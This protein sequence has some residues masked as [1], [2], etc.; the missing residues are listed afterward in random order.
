MKQFAYIV[1]FLVSVTSI[2]AGDKTVYNPHTGNLDI[3]RSSESLKR[4]FTITLD[5]GGSVLTAG[6]KDIGLRVPYNMTLTGWEIKSFPTAS[7]ATLKVNVL[8]STFATWPTISSIVGSSTPTL[9][10]AVKS[11]GTTSGWTTS[12]TAGDELDFQVLAGVA[13]ST[14]AIVNLYGT[15]W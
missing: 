13:I 10:S 14:R 8:K 15:V 2:L 1:L 7:T 3:V 9:T 4:Q 6:V 12:L 5:G 11:S